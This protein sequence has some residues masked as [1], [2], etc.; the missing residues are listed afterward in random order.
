M[1]PEAAT[2]AMARE[3]ITRGRPALAE[4]LGS[5]AAIS[6]LRPTSRGLSVALIAIV[7]L[8]VVLVTRDSTLWLVVVVVALPLAIAPVVVLARARRAKGIQ[9]HLV[10]TPPLVP[11]GDPCTLLVQLSRAG[12]AICLR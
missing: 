3:T 2:E 6:R 1:T 10:V 12:V 4:R 11:V 5:P 7:L 8:A 9:V